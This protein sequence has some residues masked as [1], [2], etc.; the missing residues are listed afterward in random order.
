MEKACGTCLKAG[1]ERWEGAVRGIE[2][3]G[4]EAS[5]VA[6]DSREMGRRLGKMAFCV[7]GSR[8]EPVR[9]PRRRTPKQSDGEPDGAG[10]GLVER[11]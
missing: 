2:G 1:A 9:K 8:L 11:D 4:R 6:R 3:E 10:R 5:M 7:Q